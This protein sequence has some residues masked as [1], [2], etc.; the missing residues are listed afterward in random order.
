MVRATE[1]QSGVVQCPEALVGK[2]KWRIVAVKVPET[3]RSRR[4]K[5]KS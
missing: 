1:G 3:K 5:L 4:K 2:G